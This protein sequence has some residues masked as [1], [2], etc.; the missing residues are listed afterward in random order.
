[1]NFDDHDDDEE[2]EE[3]EEES[4]ERDE[5][6]EEQQL[7]DDELKVVNDDLFSRE[8]LL[9]EK[10]KVADIDTE[11]KDNNNNDD[12]DDTLQSTSRGSSTELL[13]K[14]VSSLK[15]LLK[16]IKDGQIDPK[17][18]KDTE[19]KLKLLGIVL[20]NDEQVTPNEYCSVFK[21]SIDNIL[22]EFNVNNISKNVFSDPM[23]QEV[24]YK[25]H[26]DYWREASFTKKEYPCCQGKSICYFEIDVKKLLRK[27]V[28]PFRLRQFKPYNARCIYCFLKFVAK[29]FKIYLFDE[30]TISW[31]MVLNPDFCYIVDVENEYP[32]NQMLTQYDKDGYY[33]IMGPMPDLRMDQLELYT[34]VMANGEKYKGVKHKF[35]KH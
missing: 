10:Q 20:N 31:Q 29:M 1:M 4:S 22:K 17:E 32:S 11:M 27:D 16:E 6:F 8:E 34:H 21:L 3:G 28:A 14:K 23:P 12:D 18:L 33:G 5:Y 9:K 7:I 13:T 35:F 2:E 26:L 15:F 25:T 24:K 19:E 30:E